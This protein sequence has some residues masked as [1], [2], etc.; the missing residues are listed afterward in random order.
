[1]IAL[2]SDHLRE[3]RGPKPK[4]AALEARLLTSG[5]PEIVTTVVS[6]IAQVTSLQVED[7][8]SYP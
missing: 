3:L 5:D 6:T 7:W 2:D 1:M 8:R 4:S